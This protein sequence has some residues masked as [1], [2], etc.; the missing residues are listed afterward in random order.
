MNC[1]SNAGKR[2][3]LQGRL[4]EFANGSFEATNIETTVA[5]KRRLLNVLRPVERLVKAS[6]QRQA[7]RGKRSAARYVVGNFRR[8]PFHCFP[9]FRKAIKQSL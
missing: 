7:L 9:N 5:P 4:C 1:R 8:Q 2:L 3:S 6:F